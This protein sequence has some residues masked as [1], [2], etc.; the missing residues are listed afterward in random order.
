MGM[1]DS[2]IRKDD[3]DIQVK[4]YDGITGG[5]MNEYNIGDDVP[6]YKMGYDFEI[7]DKYGDDYNIFPYKTE[8]DVILIR[9]G[10]YVDCKN[11]NDL[12]DKDCEGYICINKTGERLA[13]DI[14][15]DYIE[16]KKNYEES[17][18]R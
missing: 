16:L 2:F 6:N 11:Y 18:R 12:E 14:P 4:C 17:I 1:F 5:F 8:D 13:I 9:D 10:K 7:L 15:I 3:Y